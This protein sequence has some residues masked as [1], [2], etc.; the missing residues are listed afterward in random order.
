M[1]WH[2]R[3]N[4]SC[5]LRARDTRIGTRDTGYRRT[6]GLIFRTCAHACSPSFLPTPR[7]CL[8]SPF[9]SFFSRVTR[10]TSNARS[11]GVPS[12]RETAVVIISNLHTP[13]S[14]KA[15]HVHLW[16]IA[17]RMGGYIICSNSLYTLRVNNKCRRAVPS[18]GICKSF[19]FVNVISF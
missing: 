19:L 1:V 2:S 16:N 18:S 6:I 13:P 7:S 3:W 5:N 14:G 12:R 9:R 8:V 10:A 11:R 15:M 17:T 4:V